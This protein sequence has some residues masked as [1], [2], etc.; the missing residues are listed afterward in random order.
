MLTFHYDDKPVPWEVHVFACARYRGEPRETDEMRPDFAFDRIPFDKMWA[1]DA[2]WYPLF[3]SRQ[4]FEGTFHFKD[5]HT[6]VSHEL[7]PL[8]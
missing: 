1:D 3:L 4:R 5:T 7:R 2:H 8:T 6:L